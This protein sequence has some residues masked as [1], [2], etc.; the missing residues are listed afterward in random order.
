MARSQTGWELTLGMGMNLESCV[1]TVERKAGIWGCEDSF[2]ACER[3][4]LGLESCKVNS[5]CDRHP[6]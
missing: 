6:S 3:V 5:L 1:A 4:E 2:A